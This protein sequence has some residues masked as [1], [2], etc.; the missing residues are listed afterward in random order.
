MSQSLIY[1]S[2]LFQARQDIRVLLQILLGSRSS[3]HAKFNL[4]TLTLIMPSDTAL[5]RKKRTVANTNATADG[6]HRKR[7]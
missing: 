1:V 5:T 3:A 2:F 7:Y 6:D 4:Q